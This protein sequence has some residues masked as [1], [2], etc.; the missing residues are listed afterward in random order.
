MKIDLVLIDLNFAHR[1][2]LECVLIVGE[3]AFLL[4]D[5]LGPAKKLG[6]YISNRHIG[7][8]TN[9]C[10]NT[11]SRLCSV[12]KSLPGNSPVSLKLTC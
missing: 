6:Y 11:Q 8:G 12:V 4:L 7:S 10:K 5:T 2:V 9:V 1:V 3:L